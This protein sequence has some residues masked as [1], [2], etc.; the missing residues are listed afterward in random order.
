[1]QVHMNDNESGHGDVIARR[2]L[3]F[4]GH[5]WMVRRAAVWARRRLPMNIEFDDIYQSASLGLLEAAGRFDPTFGQPFKD[6]ASKRVYGAALDA[7][8]GRRYKDHTALPLRNPEIP[9][10]PTMDRQVADR[11][12]KSVVARMLPALGPNEQEVLVLRYWADEDFS[13]IARKLRVGLG[14][15]YRLHNS[16]LEKLKREIR[17]RINIAVQG[18]GVLGRLLQSN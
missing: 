14:R 11:Q 8:R 4:G 2:N 1:M 18:P 7:F 9:V 10:L 16:A 12:L 3:L 15:V 6:Y 13:Q 5:L 17:C